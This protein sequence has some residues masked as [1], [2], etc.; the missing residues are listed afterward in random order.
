M[1]NILTI[2][3]GAILVLVFSNTLSAQKSK[4]KTNTNRD[5]KSKSANTSKP[6]KSEPE[7]VSEE[8]E[9]PAKTGASSKTDSTPRKKVIAISNFYN[10]VFGNTE[11][12]IGRQLIAL[13][14]SEFTKNGTYQVTATQQIQ[15]ILKK[16]DISFDERMDPVTA[17]KI[18]KIASANLFVFGNI[19]EFNL[20]E[21]SM[22]A[23]KMGERI[24]HTA[25]LALTVTIVDVNT[26]LALKSVTVNETAKSSANTLKVP[27][28]G[29]IGKKQ[30]M[31]SE[32]R[33]KLFTEAASKAVKAAVEQLS[34]AIEN[35]TSPAAPQNKS[36]TAKNKKSFDDTKT[37]ASA[38]DTKSASRTVSSSSNDSAKVLR[39]IKGVVYL[40][41][42]D[43]AKVGDIF[44][45]MRGAGAGKEVAVVEITEVTQGTAKAKIIDG[46]GVLPNDRV[47]IIQ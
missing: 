47:K 10:A 6:A 29:S 41:G 40:T 37:T 42:L 28:F 12:Q 23:G 46:A 19:T 8:E 45:I 44:S 21:D 32:L 18:G 31:N 2:M 43:N 1:K 20:T 5:L 30:S 9:R 17:A 38:A 7:D 11:T 24:T 14:E 39:V 15:N 36:A 22:E 33:N 13:F 4:G 16:Q 35:S 3:L 26:G 34:P 25:K 27:F